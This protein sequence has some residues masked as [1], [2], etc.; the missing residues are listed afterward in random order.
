MKPFV[1]MQTDFEK[2]V[3]TCTMEGVILGLCPE[4]RVFDNTHA[5][6]PFDTWEASFALFYVVDFWAPGTVFISVVDPGVGTPRRACVAK[7][8]NGSYV[9]TP[10]NGSLTHMKRHVGIAEVREIDESLHRLP[11]TRKVN[12][13][14]GRDLFAYCAGKLA[15]GIISYEEVGP[16]YPVDEVIAH[17]ETPVLAEN[18]RVSGMLE[19][20]DRHFGLICTNIPVAAF[21]AQGI[22]YGDRLDAVIQH[23]GREV[24]H[25]A[26][27]YERSFGH[28]AR[29]QAL[30]MISET[31]Q[32]QLAKNLENMSEEYGLGTGPEWTV[33]FTKV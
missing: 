31:Q 19:T 1:V 13:F 23:E 9:V 20:A 29:G 5:I 30:V 22:A 7:L 33:S 21:E 11:S 15:A 26:I 3:S 25:E 28:V 24:F 16:A 4:L 32:M 12:I 2:G 18:G 6:R 10:D 17:E 8:K 14:H 27:P